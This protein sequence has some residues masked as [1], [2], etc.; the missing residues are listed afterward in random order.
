MV[1]K[2]MPPLVGMFEGETVEIVGK[3][4]WKGM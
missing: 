2:P 4:N 3:S 1:N